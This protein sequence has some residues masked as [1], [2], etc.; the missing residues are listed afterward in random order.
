MNV[1]LLPNA[2]IDNDIA[3]IQNPAQI[4]HIHTVLK[5]QIGDYL[6]IGELNGN[7]GIGQIDK[8]FADKII[9]KNVQLT[10]PPPPK[11]NLTIILALPRPKV[12]RRLILDMASF[13]VNR[14]ILIN[15]IAT[16][17]SYWQSPLITDDKLQSYVLEGLQQGVDTVLPSIQKAVRFK[18]FVEDELPKLSG[19]KVVAHP[20]ADTHFK[21]HIQINGLPSVLI[22][23]AERGFVPYEIE[24]LAKN[25]VTAAAFGKR[26]LRTEAVVGALVGHWL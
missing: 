16:E 22:I 4:G 15:S 17:K 26:I 2:D 18:P 19:H 6:K 7:L 8:I 23:G 5:S 14:I 1:L 12:A 11:L 21:N 25:G 3:I 9:L 13:G 20:Y 10:T 24:L